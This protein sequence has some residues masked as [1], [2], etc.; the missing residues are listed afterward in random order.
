MNELC[1][2]CG[3]D[4]PPTWE[5]EYN[6]TYQYWLFREIEKVNKVVNQSK[7]D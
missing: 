5:H 4:H 2:K 7:F 1:T 6:L 3:K